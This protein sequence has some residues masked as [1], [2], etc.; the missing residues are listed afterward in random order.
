MLVYLEDATATIL[1]NGCLRELCKPVGG[2]WQVR[3]LSIIAHKSSWLIRQRK[4]VKYHFC[5][6]CI[7][8]SK[9]ILGS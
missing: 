6:F 3:G 1:C 9:E 2:R 7:D 4:K 8:R 5:P